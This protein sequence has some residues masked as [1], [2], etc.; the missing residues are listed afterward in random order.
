M[1]ENRSM[2]V[3]ILL[4]LVTLGIYG[5]IFTHNYAKD[6]NQV[7]EGDGQKTGGLAAVILLSMVTCGI[8]GYYWIYKVG[9]RIAI[10][11]AKR[12]IPCKTSGGNLLLWTLFG[13]LIIIGPFVVLHKMCEGLNGLCA[14]YNRSHGIQA[15]A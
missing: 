6:M 14:D 2:I 5:L 4:S 9:D 11:S 1:K 10:N 12:S 15:G 13:G 7:C 3:V 8:Y